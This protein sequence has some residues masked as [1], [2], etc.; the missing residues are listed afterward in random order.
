[1]NSNQQEFM[2]VSP[3]FTTLVWH[4]LSFK[5]KIWHLNQAVNNGSV[6]QVWKS[7][8]LAK[9]ITGKRSGMNKK[10]LSLVTKL[11]LLFGVEIFIL[12][13]KLILLKFNEDIVGTQRLQIQDMCLCN[14]HYQYLLF[15][16]PMKG[17]LFLLL[18][19]VI[20]LCQNGFQYDH[21]LIWS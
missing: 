8:G 21:F 3:F 14:K 16:N 12:F 1:M 15:D 9:N 13:P 7:K 19:S 4:T 18:E 17:W 5:G 20:Y 10:W 2:K 11:T 6:N